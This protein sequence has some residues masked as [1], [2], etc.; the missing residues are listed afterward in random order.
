[1]F[2]FAPNFGFRAGKNNTHRNNPL[3]GVS[4]KWGQ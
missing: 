2:A 3:V 4:T 1:V